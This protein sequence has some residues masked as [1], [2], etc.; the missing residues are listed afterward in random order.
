MSR[1]ALSL[2]VVLVMA[3]SAAAPAGAASKKEAEAR[4][5][6]IKREINSLRQE[7]EEASAEEADL[8][9]KVDEVRTRRAELDDKVA[10][11]DGRIDDLEDVLDEAGRRFDRTTA[12]LVQTELRLEQVEAEQHEAR[13]QLRD[14]AVAAYINPTEVS[15]AGMMMRADDVREIAAT[16]GYYRAILAEKRAV[17]D[18]VTTLKE[19]TEDLKTELGK[20]REEA[21]AQ[22]DVILEQKGRLETARAEQVAVRQEVFAE[23]QQ[24]LSLLSQIRERKAEFQS[25]ISA[26]QAESSGITRQL[27][28]VQVGQ[29]PIPAGSGRLSFPVPGA[30]ITSPFGPRVHPIFGDSRMHTGID[31][32]AG[33]GT[34]IRAAA[35]GVV[36]HAGVRGGYGNTTIIDH[37]SSLA[38]LYAHQSAIY[39][40]DGQRVT[41]GQVIGAVGCTGY[42]TGPHLH[43]EARVN[44]TPV[45]PVPYF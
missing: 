44:G 41:R 11:I 21:K 42:C 45:N 13:R 12:E 8:L 38:T 43:F 22:Q 29:T 34:P 39:V 3:L 19:Q 31:I 7:V 32:G 26:L 16:R 4:R 30:R 17:L 37:G 6:Q 2:L 40:S 10:E 18:K 20:K 35:D 33:A 36:V 28:G 27:Q 23:E 5:E 9:G 15:A 25:Q 24:E 14:R 1:R